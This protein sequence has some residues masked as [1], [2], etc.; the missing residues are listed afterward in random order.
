VIARSVGKQRAA[1]ALLAVL[2]GLA[3]LLATLGI[4]GVMSHAT[5]MRVRKIG[6]RMAHGARAPDVRRL[7]VRESLR[8]CLI[9]VAIAAAIVATY[10]PARRAARVGGRDFFPQVSTGW[11]QRSVAVGTRPLA[12][13]CGNL[14]KKVPS[15]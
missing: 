7:F 4:Y 14:W 10:L 6:I 12:P 9:G 2:G 8:L 11:C 1:S 3:L 13:D 5:T 15:P